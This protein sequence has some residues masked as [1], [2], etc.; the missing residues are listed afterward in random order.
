MAQPTY[1]TSLQGGYS[2]PQF[3][4]SY[5][6]ALQTLQPT[7]IPFMGQPP[8]TTVPQNPNPAA[9]T[10]A[11]R[12]PQASQPA[13]VGSFAGKTGMQPQQS[14]GQQFTG[15]EGGSFNFLGNIASAIFK[16]VQARKQRKMAERLI[17]ENQRPFYQIPESARRA[18]NISQGMST[19]GL[20]AYDVAQMQI[21][22]STQ[23][24]TQAMQQAASSPA[25]LLASL[26]GL[27]SQNMNAQQNLAVQNAQTRQ[28]NMLNYQ[29]AL[30]QFASWEDKQF[31]VNQWQPYE[32]A[33]AAASALTQAA[34]ANRYAAVTEGVGAL[35]SVGQTMLSLYGGGKV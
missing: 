27:Y 18:L 6:G 22:Q 35:D 16:G 24:G 4:Y 11:S 15:R 28:Q 32:Q 12:I 8:M 31:D 2:Q 17:E 7:G 34:D 20:P 1:G 26:G 29:N 23:S 13:P 14:F 25:E 3:D 5:Q 33:A 19:Q 21:D 10:A 30:N 9:T